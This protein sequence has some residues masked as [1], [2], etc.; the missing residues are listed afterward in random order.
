MPATLKSLT[1]VFNKLDVEIDGDPKAVT[2]TYRTRGYTAKV[3]REMMEAIKDDR[4]ASM[5]IPLLLATV[6]EWNFKY[7]PG[8]EVVPLTAEA[9]E[10]VPTEFITAVVDAVGD[11]VSPKGETPDE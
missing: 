10:G 11:A 1:S 4:P 6:T 2:V 7:E 9:L 3:E 5:M 8:G